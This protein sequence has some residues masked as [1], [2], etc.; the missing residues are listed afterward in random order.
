MAAVPGM[1]PG[2]SKAQPGMGA[3]GTG[4]GRDTPGAGK[5]R[6]QFEKQRQ[7]DRGT[8]VDRPPIYKPPTDYKGGYQSKPSLGPKAVMPGSSAVHGML[9]Q[10]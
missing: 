7:K 4:G 10:Y 1:V 9:P 5:Q 6:G 3:P 2:P 8:G